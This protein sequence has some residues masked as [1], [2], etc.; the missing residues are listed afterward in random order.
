MPSGAPVVDFGALAALRA[1]FPHLMLATADHRQERTRGAQSSAAPAIQATLP[2]KTINMTGVAV[3]SSVTGAQDVTLGTVAAADIPTPTTCTNV[4]AE[5]AIVVDTESP[6]SQG[7]ASTGDTIVA[8]CNATNEIS[9]VDAVIGV[10]EATLDVEGSTARAQPQVAFDDT[11]AP[12]VVPASPVV[13]SVSLLLSTRVALVPSAVAKAL[14]ALK[15]QAHGIFAGGPEVSAKVSDKGSGATEAHNA[16]AH[17]PTIAMTSTSKTDKRTQTQPATLDSLADKLE[18][19]DAPEALAATDAVNRATIGAATHRPLGRQTARLR[20]RVM[21]HRRREQT[22]HTRRVANSNTAVA[23]V[24]VVVDEA[25]AHQPVVL[26]TFDSVAVEPE[27]YKATGNLPATVSA[28]IGAPDQPNSGCSEGAV[29]GSSADISCVVASSAGQPS[30]EQPAGAITEVEKSGTDGV[31]TNKPGC[32]AGDAAVVGALPA[33]FAARNSIDAAAAELPPQV[34]ASDL[35]TASTATPGPAAHGSTATGAELVAYE[36]ASPLLAGPA[37]DADSKTNK[38]AT[39]WRA[40]RPRH[41]AM[42][43]HR[44]TPTPYPQGD[45]VK[46]RVTNATAGVTV[47]A[48]V[49]A[50][51]PLVVAAAAAAEAATAEAPWAGD[52]WEAEQ[53]KR[54]ELR[55]AGVGA[56]LVGYAL[57]WAKWTANVALGVTLGSVVGSIAMAD[58]VYDRVVGNDS[59][60]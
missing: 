25:T 9:R 15:S 10:P 14:F 42:P 4:A 51:L 40:S 53:L 56:G 59:F 54:K 50:M 46:K 11:L 19:Y 57:G 27:V 36:A 41:R 21:R 8:G 2:R 34:V 30:T 5:S 6:T 60:F 55:R 35:P 16:S 47:A 37:L 58:F 26:A 1:V 28:V 12:I 39:V 20:H 44:R 38:A 23:A 22:I 45:A 43:L 17:S 33:G 7:A 49:S 24:A 48:S 18:A 31:A 52:L 13:G 3:D 32:D 29:V